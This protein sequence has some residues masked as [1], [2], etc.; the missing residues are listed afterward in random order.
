MYFIHYYSLL[1]EKPPMLNKN[2]F[3]NAQK[4]GFE[5]LSFKIG[6]YD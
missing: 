1:T 4:K 2:H 5:I 3:S 6:V